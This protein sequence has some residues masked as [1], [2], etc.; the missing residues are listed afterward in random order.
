MGP[1]WV[2]RHDRYR[3]INSHNQSGI[4]PGNYSDRD[5]SLG[6][7]F[8]GV[9][10]MSLLSVLRDR[11]TFTTDWFS[12]A[13]YYNKPIF[14]SRTFRNNTFVM[15]AALMIGVFVIDRFWRLLPWD[16][17][18]LLLASM[19]C[20][21]AVWNRTIRDHQKLQDRIRALEPNPVSE[22]LL[23]AAAGGASFGPF[24]LYVVA[25]ALISCLGVAVA[26]WQLTLSNHP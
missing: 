16:S 13:G 14:E 3:P 9:P 21:V 7:R 4:C 10:L 1:P 12:E 25:F 17:R 2:K 19:L 23:R 22:E 6:R 8:C 20:L 15:V 26:H 11:F 24:V 5:C 18:W